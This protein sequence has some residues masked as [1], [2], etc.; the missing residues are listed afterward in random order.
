MHPHVLEALVVGL[1]RVEQ[2]DGLA[3]GHRN[4]DVGAGLH[5]RERVNGRLSVPVPGRRWH[6]GRLTLG[7]QRGGERAQLAATDCRDEEERQL[8]E[9]VELVRSLLDQDAA[10]CS[11]GGLSDELVG[12]SQKKGETLVL[13]ELGDVVESIRP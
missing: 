3:V 5:V 12:V 8:D 13:D 11:H 6:A 4:D 10:V 2:P 9:G 7:S 1:E